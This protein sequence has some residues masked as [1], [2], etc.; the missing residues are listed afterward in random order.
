MKAGHNLFGKRFIPVE[1]FLK[2]EEYLEL[3]NSADVAL[4]NHDRQQGLGNILTLLYLGKKVFLRPDTNS[5]RYFTSR[6]IKVFD[7][8]KADRMSVSEFLF[9][10]PEDQAENRRILR[11]E[12]SVENYIRNWTTILEIQ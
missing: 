6:G 8:S 11:E 1:D 3:I 5:Y 4:M 9:I 7:I 2:P 12:F 10:A